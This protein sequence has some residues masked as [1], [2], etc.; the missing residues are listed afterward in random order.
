MVWTQLQ[1]T[2]HHQQEGQPTH[3]QLVL[4][5]SLNKLQKFQMGHQGIEGELNWFFKI[6]GYLS[7]VS[8]QSNAL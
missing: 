6:T 8:L 7:I 3:R 5:S 4:A 1:Q 2:A